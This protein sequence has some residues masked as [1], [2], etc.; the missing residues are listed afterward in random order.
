MPAGVLER[1]PTTDTFSLSQDQEEFFFSLRLD[2]LDV[3]IY[4]LDHGLGEDEVAHALELTPEQVAR[5]Y[6]DIGRKRAH[7]EY[8]KAP[9]VLLGPDA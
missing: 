7:A 6:E 4:A 9:P 2:Q 1:T 3:C 8:L 5:V